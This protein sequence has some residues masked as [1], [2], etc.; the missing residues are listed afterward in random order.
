M[1]IQS[2]VRRYED[3][4]DVKPGWQ[5]RGVSHALELAENGTL[6]GIRKLGDPSDKKLS[7]LTLVLP[8][9]DTR[10]GTKAYFL[11]DD[12]EY[13]LGLADK[14]WE[15]SCK[16]HIELLGN[17][18]T[19]AAKAITAYFSAG[20][21]EYTVNYNK[22]KPDVI[23]SYTFSLTSGNFTISDKDMIS[24]KFVFMVNGKRVDYTDGDDEIIDI[25][26][27]S[28][29]QEGE[30]RICLVTG[31]PDS[32]IRLHYKVT[33]NGVTMGAQPLISMNDQTSFRSYGSVP[34]DPAAQI[35]A[36][37]AFAYATALNDLLSDT[38]HHQSLG[39]DTLVYWSEGGGEK[40]AAVFASMLIAEPDSDEDGNL[41]A[42]MKHVSQGKLPEIDGVKWDNP[43][44][45]M[46][47]SPNAAR[48]S[49]R[50]FYVKEFGT[51]M[52][53]LAKH[54]DNLDIYSSR[55]EKYKR[56]PYWILLS[57]TTIKKSASAAVP[58][59]GGQL[60]NSIL[61]GNDYPMTLYNA[62]LTRIRAGEDVNRTKAA[63]IKSIL[64]R[65]FNNEKESG[66]TTVALNPNSDDKA[67]TLGR[68][69]AAL[70]REQS[71]AAGGSLNATI[72][73]RYFA[74]AC[75]NPKV[76]FVTLLKLSM[77]HAK[78]LGEKGRWL[79]KL[80]S[81]LLA[82]LDDSNPYPA[83]L[84]LEGQG[85]FILGYYHQTQEFFTSKKDKENNDN[86][87]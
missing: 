28:Q 80:K 47:L 12:G 9:A 44:Y 73:D 1:I 19:S 20:A 63:I 27:S 18:D 68:L 30:Q 26:E 76:A 16:L 8:I 46:C 21:P 65:N 40:E 7:K 11:C 6:L 29:K 2:L 81:E 17:I 22:D 55:D 15:A 59:L 86:E 67:Y 45:I 52:K 84:S 70:E 50:F 53:N 41:H 66:E 71:N 34:K 24:A 58:L 3:T 83:S 61:T 57:E 43:F 49:V 31:K 64:I 10:T 39:A 48:I 72:R 4:A 69:F 38:N 23:D 79:E 78:K 82:K 13:L 62:I 33:L 74:S 87:Q 32:I 37:A 36:K 75:A 51:I 42:A 77:N 56:L 35:G 60:M 25:W 54:Y 14:K 85:K 5:K